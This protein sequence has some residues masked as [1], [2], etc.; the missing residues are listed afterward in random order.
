[1]AV[2]EQTSSM[3]ARIKSAGN[4][5]LDDE[6]ICLII[7]GIMSNYGMKRSRLREV[8]IKTI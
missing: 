8:E 2:A 3:V 4:A 6:N 7:G 5:A 1:M